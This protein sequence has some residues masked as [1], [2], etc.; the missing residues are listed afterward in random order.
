M[1][2]RTVSVYFTLDV[3]VSNEKEP[4][5]TFETRYKPEVGETVQT[6]NWSRLEIEKVMYGSHI[7]TDATVIVTRDLPPTRPQL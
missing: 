6:E 2:K 3:A 5:D 1:E 4:E 7:E